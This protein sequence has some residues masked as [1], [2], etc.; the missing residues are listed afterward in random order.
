MNRIEKLLEIKIA[1]DYEIVLHSV[2]HKVVMPQWS[3]LSGR[4]SVHIAKL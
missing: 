1:A 4:H 2:G 3:S